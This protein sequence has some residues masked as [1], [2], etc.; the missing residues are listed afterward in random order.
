M[1]VKKDFSRLIFQISHVIG[2][3]ESE[4]K[5]PSKAGNEC[6][7]CDQIDDCRRRCLS[8][9]DERKG[10]L[11]GI[12]SL[13]AF[14]RYKKES[15]DS[16]YDRMCETSDPEVYFVCRKAGK[17]IDTPGCCAVILYSQFFQSFEKRHKPSRPP[18]IHGHHESTQAAD[19]KETNTLYSCP[20][21]GE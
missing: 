6:I 18:Q 8:W 15:K 20:H 4:G 2:R 12:L 11:L 16:F 5:L 19:G 14:C 7:D 13:T 1:W 21:M 9:G 3:D 10:D 17:E